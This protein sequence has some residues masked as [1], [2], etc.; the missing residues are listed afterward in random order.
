MPRKC[1][2]RIQLSPT[3]HARL[4]GCARKYTSPYRDVIRARIVLYAVAV[5]DNDEIAARLDMVRA[6]PISVVDATTS[7]DDDRPGAGVRPRTSLTRVF[8]QYY[9]GRRTKV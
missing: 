9:D 4:E 1:P 8:R 2:L 5:L 7:G 6:A 3:E